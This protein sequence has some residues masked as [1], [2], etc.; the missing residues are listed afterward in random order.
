MERKKITYVATI[1]I[2]LILSILGSTYAYLTASTASVPNSIQAASN[3]YTLSMN[4]TPLYNNFRIIPMN[5]ADFLKALNN[6]CKDKYNRGA[7]SAYKININGYDTKLNAISGKMNVTLSNIENLSY[8]FLEKKDEVI[9][10]DI[11]V[12]IEDD[13]YCITKE[14]TP[15]VE[16]D[17]LPFG[18]YNIAN[19]TDKDFLLVLW[20]T[21]LNESQNDF[22]LGDY[23]ATITFLMGDGGTITGNI[24]ASIGKENELQSQSG[25]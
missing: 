8:A 21:N 22:D 17:D 6:N 4:I 7:C 24:A 12:T 10:D 18:S 9:N 15:V 13:I 2:V 20:L 14:A 19:T 23:N 3:A 11:C 5:D 16:E 25:E 1:I